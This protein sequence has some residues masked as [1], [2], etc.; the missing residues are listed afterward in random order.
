MIPVLIAVIVII[1]GGFL[2]FALERVVKIHRQKA[3]TGKEELIGGTAVT[4]T[5]LTPEGEVFFRGER[6]AAISESDNIGINEK[7]IITRID[8]LTLYVKTREPDQ[9]VTAKTLPGNK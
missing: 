5:S 1:F 3:T 4:H 6:W 8:G 7:V 2:V 9:E